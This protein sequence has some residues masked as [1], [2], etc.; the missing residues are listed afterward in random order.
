MEAGTLAKDLSAL[1]QQLE[2][3]RECRRSEGESF[4]R[5]EEPGRASGERSMWSSKEH[6]SHFLSL[7]AAGP[8]SEIF[9]SSEL[10]F[11]MSFKVLKYNFGI[12]FFLIKN[13][14]WCL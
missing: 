4:G 5:M 14:R 3:F 10:I 13:S 6:L 2:T 9:L 7:L 1:E 12:A 8:I 11:M